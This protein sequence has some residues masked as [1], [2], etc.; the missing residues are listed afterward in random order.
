MSTGCLAGTDRLKAREP[1]QAGGLTSDNAEREL[2]PVRGTAVLEE[3]NALPGAELH[4]PVGNR[5]HLARAREDGANV[6]GAIVA[7]F[8]SVLEPWRVL[9]DQM[10]EKS[11]E[12]TTGGGIRILHDDQAAARVP[13]ENGDGPRGN[14]AGNNRGGHRLC[15]L[16][17]SFTFR[18]DGEAGGMENHCRH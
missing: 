17:G 7:A 2:S 9:R 10:F 15:N 13:D 6:R 4:A 16:I 14:S 18:R 1:S 3:E 11:L 5:D 12:I 8:R